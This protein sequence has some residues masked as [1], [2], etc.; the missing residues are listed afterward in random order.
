ME[1]IF[2]ILKLID[3]IINDNYFLSFI[4]YSLILYIY[5]SFS[6]PGIMI[7]W[8]FSGYAYGFYIGYLS[9][10]II[11]TIGSFNLF[12]LSKN[13]YNKKFSNKFSKSINKINNIIK[14]Q[15][16]EILIIFRMLPI[17]A[18]FFIQNISLSFLNISNIKYII[19]TFI[20]LSPL[21]IILVLIGDTFTHINSFKNFEFDK[22]EFNK[23]FFLIFFILIVLTIRIFY[24]YKKNKKKAL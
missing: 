13:I 22:L 19:V 1:S 17:N 14:N 7:L 16:Y 2:E 3:V 8:A 10:V 4:I 9:S 5:S 24:S 11:T 15:S 12:Y 20:G 23:I 21:I 18:P 6:L